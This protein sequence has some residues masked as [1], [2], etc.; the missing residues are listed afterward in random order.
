M[1]AAMILQAP[2]SPPSP[3]ARVRA[4]TVVAERLLTVGDTTV[5]LSL[6]SNRAAVVSKIERDRQVFFRMLT[7]TEHEFNVYLVA[8]VRDTAAIGRFD[9]S[10]EGIGGARAVVRLQLTDGDPVEISYRSGEV[11]DLATARLVATLDDLE[12]RVSETAPFHQQ[13]RDW[14]PE[15]GDVVELVTGVRARVSD[16]RADGS[17]TLEHE[18]VAII[19][20]L[21]EEGRVERIRRVLSEAP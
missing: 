12:R 16:V 21:A 1:L 3:A 20:D 10:S 4:P 7:L 18:G 2:P 5:R 19:E 6:F 14:Q 17:I 11:L 8:L 9:R 15:K 13:L